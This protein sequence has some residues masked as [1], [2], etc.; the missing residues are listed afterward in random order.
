MPSKPRTN[1]SSIRPDS[2]GHL[3]PEHR[4]PYPD[5]PDD[6][7]GLVG[8][9]TGESVPGSAHD[10]PIDPLGQGEKQIVISLPELEDDGGEGALSGR[11][12]ETGG[13]RP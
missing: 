13:Q 9:P 7:P 5:I 3:P 12:R 6:S 8:G 11:P 10:D 2:T 4:Q 1:P